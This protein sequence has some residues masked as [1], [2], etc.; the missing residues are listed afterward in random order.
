M[1]KTF[2]FWLTVPVEFEGKCYITF[3]NAFCWFTIGKKYHRVDGPAVVEGSGT[4]QWWI[5]GIR[6]T[7]E[8]YWLHPLVIQHKLESVLNANISNLGPNTKYL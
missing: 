8:Q 3:E 2:L 5:N 1:M 7:E 6:C 4:Q